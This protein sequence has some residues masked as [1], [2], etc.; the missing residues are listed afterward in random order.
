[1]LCFNFTH[2]VPWIMLLNLWWFTTCF[3]FSVDGT[4]IREFK[5]MESKGVAFPKNQPMRIYSSLWNADDWA[6]RGGLVKTD[7]SQA[8]FTASYRNFNA[9]ACVH[10]GSSS[11]CSSNSGS[12]SAWYSQELDSTNQ[13]RLGWVQKNYMIYNYCTDTKRFPQGLPPECQ[14]SWIPTA[15][16][17]HHYTVLH[18]S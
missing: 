4:P 10:S 12:S 11:S 3:S 17:Y 6:T 9:D 14:A 15:N 18:S 8:P 7:W 2:G 16:K 1:M 13:E 5:N